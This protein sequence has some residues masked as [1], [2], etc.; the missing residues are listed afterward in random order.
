MIDRQQAHHIAS[1]EIT[2]RGLGTGVSS[3]YAPGEL[4]P[5]APN[6]YYGPDLNAAWVAYVERPLLG[7]RSSTIVVI[8][9]ETGEVLYAGSANDEG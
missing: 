9:S 5:R 6:L 3:L 2:N 7:L 4:V 1:R 8:S